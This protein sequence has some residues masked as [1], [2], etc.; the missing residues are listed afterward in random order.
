MI[1]AD[2]IA[3]GTRGKQ[4]GSTLDRPLEH[5]VACHRRIEDR[6]AIL[7]RAGN[8]LE[9]DRAAALEAINNSLAFFETNVARHTAD[10]EESFFPRLRERVPEGELT[11]LARLE[12]DHVMASSLLEDLRSTAIQIR[13]AEAGEDIS[14]VQRT[15]LETTAKLT[16]LFRGHI[17]AEDEELI[18]LASKVLPEDTLREIAKEM[19]HRRAQ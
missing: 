14:R 15:F 9:H 8:H 3:R 4:E 19:K 18:R 16:E 6:L 1:T 11:L 5:L 13:T 17:A 12:G 7:D 10:E 2:Q